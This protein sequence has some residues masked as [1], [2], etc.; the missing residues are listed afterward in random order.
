[1]APIKRERDVETNKPARDSGSSKRRRQYTEQDSRLAKIYAN[2]ADENHR[3]RIQAAKELVVE[4]NPDKIDDG[5]VVDRALTRLIRGLCSGRKAA[6]LGFSIALTEVVRQLYDGVHTEPKVSGAYSMSRLLELIEERTQPEGDVAGQ[7]RRDH[8]FG[9]LFALKSLEQSSILIE[10]DEPGELWSSYVDKVFT[11]ALDVVWL[12]QECGSLLLNAI[13]KLS[14]Y[15][16]TRGGKYVE[17]I[18]NLMVQRGMSK[19]PEG[20][21]IWLTAKA[22]FPDC[23]YPLG[24]WH[25][26]DPLCTKETKTLSNILR[27]AGPQEEQVKT[28]T[29]QAKPGLA[30]KIVLEK[31][32]ARA[33]KTSGPD[34]SK[35]QKFWVEV[36]DNGL[37]SQNSVPE[38]KLWGFQLFSDMLQSAPKWALASLFSRNLMRCLINHLGDDERTLHGAAQGALKHLVAQVKEC[39]DLAPIIVREL[40][41]EYGS[42]FFDRLTNT[43]TVENILKATD[44]ASFEDIVGV[45]SDL[46]EQPPSEDA[47]KAQTCRTMLADLVLDVFRV[48]SKAAAGSK[49]LDKAPKWMRLVLEFFARFAYLVP[50]EDE[51]QFEIV[52]ITRKMFQIRLSSCLT[53]IFTLK[54]ENPS[55]WASFV[56]TKLHSPPGDWELTIS[57]DDVVVKKVEH[58]QNLFSKMVVRESK[59]S[60]QRKPAFRALILA[61]SLT[62]LQLYA[63]DGDALLLL[64]DLESCYT[65]IIKGNGDDEAFTALIEILLSFL[66]NPSKLYRKVAEEVFTT[67][68]PSVTKDSL[69]SLIDI[70]ETPETSAGQRE[71]FANE[72]EEDRLSQ[73][74]SDVEE[75]S[76]PEGASDVEDISDVEKASDVEMIDQVEA[77]SATDDSD[78]ND[79]EDSNGSDEDSDDGELN[80]FNALLAETLKTDDTNAEGE[81]SDEDMNDDQM[82]ALDDQLANIFKQ[83]KSQTQGNSKKEKKKTQEQMIN[84]KTRVLDLLT[85]YVKREYENP[86]AVMLVLPLLRLM[87]TSTGPSYRL[88]SRASQVLNLYMNTNGRAKA[89]IRPENTGFDETKVWEYLREVHTEVKKPAAGPHA[90]ACSRASLFFAKLIVAADRESYN[91]V[92]DLYAETQ[93]DWFLKRNSPIQATFFTGWISWS[94][95][96]RCER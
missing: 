15:P 29:W 94:V 9:R 21:A 48:R 3:T 54:P 71:L 52:P 77:A 76:D 33:D 56:I 96:V 91:K 74:G 13:T 59:A 85:I 45:L 55:D 37:F 10:P 89:A 16:A 41:G 36:V 34:V 5:N 78:S 32:I 6:R 92:V 82:M 75:I 43:K 23:Q 27:Q 17:R 35:F 26:D 51:I 67:F 2:L 8:L 83:R 63:G 81:S 30:W 62:F 61:F 14:K 57:A 38:K 42:P 19:T 70:L 84:F 69:Q 64:E 68:T 95:N 49:G 88:P 47:M 65:S 22:A 7:E 11:L 90:Q 66:S 31:V 58:A 86:L 46:T 87:R 12:R 73:L 93:K 72:E 53:H 80:R 40:M 50:R 1:M 18:L 39:P 25:K 24:V 20:V 28:G 60:D 4:L 44:D 79:D